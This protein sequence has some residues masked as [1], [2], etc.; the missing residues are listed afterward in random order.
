MNKTAKE[1][2][3]FIKDL[4]KND[5][6]DVDV[7]IAPPFTSLD[8]VK[9]N[10][11]GKIYIGSQNI[12]KFNDGA[13]TGEV[14]GKMLKEFCDYVIIGH[15]ERRTIFSEDYQTIREKI[16]RAF[17][18]NLKVILC[19]GEEAEVRE[20][21]K[22]NDFV[23]EE[24]LAALENLDFN[25]DNLTIAY[26]P[27][28]AIG[29][30]KTC[31]SEDAQDMCKFIRHTLSKLNKNES[32]FIRILYGGSVKGSNAKNLLACPDIDGALVGGASLEAK[33]FL[34]IIN[35]KENI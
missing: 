1:A 18:N 27:I 16:L 10:S 35:Y 28:W 9:R 21:N 6:K 5:F 33:E 30:G 7:L 25:R 8:A 26:E 17:E 19:L 11:N 12:C 15:S 22:Q 4:V 13:Y 29:T 34:K 24:I 31:S 23:K 2:E 14:S 20:K 32:E 3:E